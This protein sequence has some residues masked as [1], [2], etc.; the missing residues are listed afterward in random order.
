MLTI[1]YLPTNFK[2]WEKKVTF[3]SVL[4]YRMAQILIVQPQY[5]SNTMIETYVK[6]KH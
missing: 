1:L 5:K 2:Y 4:I 3:T 6:P